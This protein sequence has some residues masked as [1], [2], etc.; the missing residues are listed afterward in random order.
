MGQKK[1]RGKR[2]EMSLC[3]S[4][5]LGRCLGP[6]LSRT[7]CRTWSGDA[8]LHLPIPKESEE[9]VAFSLMNQGFG[10]RAGNRAA[11]PTGFSSCWLQV[12]GT[13]SS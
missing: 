4:A 13:A 7:I 1:G 12:S 11:S 5:G 2:E 6:E 3:P 9:G 8:A 10:S